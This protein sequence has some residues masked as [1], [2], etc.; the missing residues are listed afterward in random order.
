MLGC[1][2]DRKYGTPRGCTDETCMRLPDGQTCGVCARFR[3]CESWLGLT[4]NETACDWH[5]RRFLARL[6]AQPTGGGGE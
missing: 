2:V 1:C 4:G 3:Y 5:P 6:P